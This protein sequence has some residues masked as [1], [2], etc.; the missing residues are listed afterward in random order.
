MPDAHLL[1][2]AFP[3]MGRAQPAAVCV[4]GRPEYALY[5]QDFLYTTNQLA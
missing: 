1:V 3:T 2:S 4:H 5:Q